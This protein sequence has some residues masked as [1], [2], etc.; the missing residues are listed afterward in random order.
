GRDVVVEQEAEIRDV[1]A[2]RL[3]LG[4]RGTAL[5][6]LERAHV[7]ALRQ[8]ALEQRVGAQLLG[9]GRRRELAGEREVLR[10]HVRA[11]E[12]AGIGAVNGENVSPSDDTNR[13]G[14]SNFF[15]CV[16]PPCAS[17]T[18]A[19]AD[20]TSGLWASASETASS[21]VMEETGASARAD[22]GV[23]AATAARADTWSLDMALPCVKGRRSG[24]AYAVTG[25]DVFGASRN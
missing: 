6:G 20:S 7:A 25:G 10:E 22:V 3:A 19:S 14:F 15:D 4:G 8:G 13:L 24:T 17:A 2:A 16:S 18:S 11:D 1:L 9:V 23:S 5:A 12:V 21:I